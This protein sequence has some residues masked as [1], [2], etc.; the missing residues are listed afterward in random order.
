[1]I[2]F[3]QRKTPPKLHRIKVLQQKWQFSEK[4]GVDESALCQIYVPGIL[5]VILAVVGIFLGVLPVKLTGAAFF[6]ALITGGAL[7]STPFWGPILVALS[8]AA[9]GTSIGF[10]IRKLYNYGKVK[11]IPANF[12][13]PLDKVGHLGAEIV[14]QP[15][16][17]MLRKDKKSLKEICEILKPF[18][19]RWGYNLEYAEKIIKDWDTNFDIIECA[20]RNMF[21]TLCDKEWSRKMPGKEL[22][23]RCFWNNAFDVFQEVYQKTTRQDSVHGY[24]EFMKPIFT[25]QKYP[26]DN[27]RSKAKISFEDWLKQYSWIID[28]LPTTLKNK[29]PAS[30]KEKKK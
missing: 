29:L 16:L 17:I 22:L 26:E 5:S 14:F 15:A 19:S 2:S 6:W 3:K 7:V 30:L 20:S 23:T 1:M 25:K 24:Y 12:K 10:T 18:F 4:V 9:A 8:I 21:R 11:S 27:S 13:E 28:M